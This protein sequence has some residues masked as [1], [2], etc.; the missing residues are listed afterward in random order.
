VRREARKSYQA[1]EPAEEAARKLNV[2]GFY[3]Q[4]ANPERLPLIV[5][6]LYMEFEGE[7]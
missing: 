7:M 5:Q 4:W 1:G 6:R 3:T 2:G